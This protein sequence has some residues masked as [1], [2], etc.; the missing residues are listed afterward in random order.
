MGHLCDAHLGGVGGMAGSYDLTKGFTYDNYSNGRWGFH[1]GTEFG[2][3][4]S[5]FCDAAFF[6]VL[7]TFG[8]GNNEINVSGPAAQ[9][10]AYIIW[11][12]FQMKSLLI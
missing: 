4:W 10:S 5:R 1:A 12:C 2:K 6:E 11:M 3:T 8:N 7:Q 9:L